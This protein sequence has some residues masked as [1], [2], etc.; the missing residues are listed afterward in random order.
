MSLPNIRRKEGRIAENRWAERG[1]LEPA[2]RAAFCVN[3]G[4]AP[5][6]ISLFGRPFCLRHLMLKFHG[7]AFSCFFCFSHREGAV[8]M[9]KPIW[10]TTGNR[11][12]NSVWGVARL[13]L[14]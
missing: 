14:G 4:Q 12:G 3:G 7:H 6:G 11:H 1:R 2:G 10:A 8:G 9:D 5:L 13:L